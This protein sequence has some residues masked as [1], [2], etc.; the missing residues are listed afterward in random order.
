M[1]DSCAAFIES[2]LYPCKSLEHLPLNANGKVDRKAL[3]APKEQAEVEQTAARSASS[4]V[5]EVV[6]Q[7]WIHTR[8]KGYYTVLEV[9]RDVRTTVLDAYMYQDLPFEKIVEMLKLGRTG[10]QVPL[11]NVLFVLQ[12]PPSSSLPV[13]GLEVSPINIESHTAKIQP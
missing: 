7:L 12:N 3:P 6:T 9:L 13:Q 5:E 10:Y 4:Q 2:S 1:Y 11:I 8:L